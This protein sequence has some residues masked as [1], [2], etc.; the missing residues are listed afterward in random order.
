MKHVIINDGEM[1]LAFKNGR[2]V[3]TLGTGKYAVRSGREIKI[4]PIDSEINCG[5][6][7]LE[8]LLGNEEFADKV[9]ALDVKNGEI[10]LVYVNGIYKHTI[11][12]VGKH[13]FWK[14]AGE[15]K[16]DVIDITDPEVG[17]KVPAAVIRELCPVTINKVS[18]AEH[19]KAR[20]YYDGKFVK[21]LD[22]GT[23]YFWRKSVKNVTT[24][25]VDTRLLNIDI[26][27]Q[28]VLTQDKIEIRVNLVC[29][30]RIA[31]YVNIAVNVSDYAEQLHIYA[32]LALREYV[33]RYKL[34]ELLENKGDMSTYVYGKLKEKENELCIEVKEAGVKD[35]IIPGEIR[36]IM[37]TVLIAEK[38]AQA[39]VIA[40]R[41][42]VAST[43]SLLNTAKLMEENETLY[44]LKELEY[45]EKICENVGN[46]TLNG[47]GDMV[48]QLVNLIG[49]KK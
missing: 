21:L 5:N 37:N 3:K 35:I 41:E 44:K 18:V 43:R 34:D 6:S 1:G 14:K 46:L 39:N 17:D 49:G 13:A 36:Q 2:F 23:Y 45:M 19:E 15:H 30:Y 25:T 26:R 47:Q 7:T 38:K 22:A 48:S 28:E 31:D 4:L 33:G 10:A 9:D 12:S 42:E 32:Q 20:L 16:F 8:T 40:R 27:G 11:N 24:E 29:S